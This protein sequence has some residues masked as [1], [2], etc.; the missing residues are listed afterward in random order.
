MSVST[1]FS[2]LIGSARWQALWAAWK[3]EAEICPVPLLG[4]S[5]VIAALIIGC[6]P[7]GLLYAAGHNPEAPTNFP[8]IVL[9]VTAAVAIV[10][11]W[12]MHLSYNRVLS[13]RTA[14]SLTHTAFALGCIPAV[15]LLCAFPEALLAQREVLES[16]IAQGSALKPGA[17]ATIV[18]V[19]L[20]TAVWAAVTEEVIFRGLLV[21]VLRRWRA[22]PTQR[23]RNVVA[24]ILSAVLFGL[25]HLPSWG[26]VASIALIGLGLGFALGFIANG[27]KL[28]PLVVYHFAFDILSISAAV[29]AN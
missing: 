18:A 20:L 21:S 14:L 25:A 17:L 10:L 29:L 19:S 3:T 28:M 7:F 1:I 23:L 5:A 12:Q 9:G 6:A 22:I 24:C 16:G 27:E 11:R 26:P 15:A 8:L 4:T 2:R 13:W